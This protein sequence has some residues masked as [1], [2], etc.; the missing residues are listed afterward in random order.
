MHM[1]KKILMLSAAM[2]ILGQAVSAEE[3]TEPKKH[4]GFRAS[5]K[6]KAHHA[7]ERGKEMAQHAKNKAHSA[8]RHG[9]EMAQHAREKAHHMKESAKAKAH[10]SMNYMRG[11]E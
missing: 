6:A 7:M 2:F 9:K 5:M 1:M 11:G 10:E 3:S 4:H 8:M